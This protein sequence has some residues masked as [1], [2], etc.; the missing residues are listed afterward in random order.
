MNNPIT[1]FGIASRIATKRVPKTTTPIKIPAMLIA[2]IAS[3]SRSRTKS[4]VP[5]AISISASRASPFDN[6]GS[7][8]AFSIESSSVS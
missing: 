1:M 4:I 3:P 7:P 5:I 6:G 2:I 8:A